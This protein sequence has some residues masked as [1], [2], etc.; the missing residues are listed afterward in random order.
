MTPA[1]PALRLAFAAALL[2]PAVPVSFPAFAANTTRPLRAEPVAPS[3]YAIIGELG[4]PS[5]ENRGNALNTGF[6]VGR[7]GV[8][9]VDTGP[10]HA[11]GAQILAAVGAVT[12]LPVALAINTH[13]HPENTLGNSAFAS[14]GIP[15]LAHTETIV[16]MR[17]NC[18]NCLANMRTLLGEEIMAGTTAVVPNRSV[19]RTTELHVAGRRLR[20]VFHGPGHSTGDLAVL[21]IETGVLFS[22]GL[23]SLDRIPALRFANTRGWIRA[24]DRLAREPIRRLVPGNGPVSAPSRIRETRD[25]LHELLAE[26]EHHRNKGAGVLDAIQA[27]T[28]PAFRRWALYREL[29]PQNVQHVYYELDKEDL[30]Q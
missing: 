23:V 7:E 20:L 3:V 17:R 18:E 14:R 1:R 6:I 24:L 9:V 8:I 21:D 26:V 22:G 30:A 27:C 4:Q 5:P 28:L 29:H 15:I 16:A 13:A 25:Y 11:H 2:I 19:A 10:S 12:P